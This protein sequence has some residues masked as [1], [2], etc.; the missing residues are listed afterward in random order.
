MELAPTIVSTGWAAGINAYLTVAM[1]GLLGRAG[2]GEV[3]D[4][5]QSEGVIIAALVMAGVEFVVDKFPYLDNLWDLVGTVVRPA[6]GSALGLEF[7][8][9]AEV[10]GLDEVLSAGGSGSMALASHA[11]KAGLRLGINTSPEPASN[12]VVSLA[13]DAAVAGVVWLATEEPVIAAAI[14]VILLAAGLALVTLL[15]T[16]IR[17]GWRA[18]AR[19]RGRGP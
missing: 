9:Q 15:A 4:P 2:I 19:Y 12:I 6:I 14:A 7:A 11:V 1:L 18:L 16:R 17:R 13:E 10:S 8:G 5:L 3:P